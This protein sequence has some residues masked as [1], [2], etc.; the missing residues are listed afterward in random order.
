VSFVLVHGSWQ[1]PFA[2]GEVP[3]RLRAA[4]HAVHVPAL[5]AAAGT[6]PGDHGAAVAALL[7]RHDLRASV[8]AGHS[9]GGMVI[10]VAAELAAGRVGALVY[11][12]A[13]VP[14]DGDSVF[15]LKPHVA[16]ERRARA[17]EGVMAPPR[18][19]PGDPPQLA[20]RL[21]PFPLASQETPVLL[22]GA[23]DRLP[24]TYVHALRDDFGSQAARARAR[25]F[26]VVPLDTGHHVALEAPAAL[27][28]ILLEAGARAA[29]RRPTR[30]A[31]WPGTS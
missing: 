27:A 6:T 28:R 10:P 13:F 29:Q 26:E 8:L 9:Y 4:G 22:T 1:G 21:R 15:S 2:W 20:G 12:D 14:G 11:V 3:G 19:D 24:A 25:G 16:A 23:A 5:D 17:R 18:P 30:L 31:P 7:E